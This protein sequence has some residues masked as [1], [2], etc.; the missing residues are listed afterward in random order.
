MLRRVDRIEPRLKAWVTIRRE[1]AIA[2]AHECTKE[3]ETGRFRGPLH[4]IPIGLKDIFYTA[5]MKT[6]SA[7]KILADF[8]PSYDATVAA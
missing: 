2:V 5:G 3:A 8:V 4:G 1:E 6:T 7:S